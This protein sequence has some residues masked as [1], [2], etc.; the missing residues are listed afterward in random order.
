MYSL[1][2]LRI[3]IT[4]TPKINW[5]SDFVG[6]HNV[7]RDE[8]HATFYEVH[9]RFKKGESKL[10]LMYNWNNVTGFRDTQTFCDHGNPSEWTSTWHTMPKEDCLANLTLSRKRLSVVTKRSN[11]PWARLARNSKRL[12]ESSD[13]RGVVLRARI[14]HPVFTKERSK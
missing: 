2:E 3:R 7:A 8:K 14:K 9:K 4:E 6:M 11:W 1:P 13:T 5:R 10:G 12:V